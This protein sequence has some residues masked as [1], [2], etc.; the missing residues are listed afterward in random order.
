[1]S[2]NASVVNHRAEY[3]DVEIDAGTDVEGTW[4]CSG[5][6]NPSELSIDDG[7]ISAMVEDTDVDDVAP[8][9]TVVASAGCTRSSPAPGHWSLKVTANDSPPDL[10]VAGELDEGVETCGLSSQDE[11]ASLPITSEVVTAEELR[12]AMPKVQMERTSSLRGV[13]SVGQKLVLDSSDKENETRNGTNFR[14]ANEGRTCRL[15]SSKKVL[16]ECASQD[17]VGLSPQE[18]GGKSERSAIAEG[19]E[20]GDDMNSSLKLPLSNHRDAAATNFIPL[21]A[22]SGTITADWGSLDYV[23]IDDI[24]PEAPEHVLPVCENPAASAPDNDMF[25]GSD[26]GYGL[27]SLTRNEQNSASTTDTAGTRRT[28]SLEQDASTP[29]ARIRSSSKSPYKC[30][31]NGRK[32]SHDSWSSREEDRNERDVCGRQNKSQ[33]SPD[34]GSTHNHGAASSSHASAIVASLP[35]ARATIGAPN[36]STGLFAP[37]DDGCGFHFNGVWN[38]RTFTELQS[39]TAG[40]GQV[41]NSEVELEAE[42]GSSASEDEDLDLVAGYMGSTMSLDEAELLDVGM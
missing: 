24:A 8:G 34:S 21:P 18:T 6:A 28:A 23:G 36:W 20:G 12:S 15:I 37:E 39:K 40:D 38:A 42:K 9:G 30:T 4:E 13:C 29:P 5:Q 2:K 17:C 31:R 7:F 16:G 19:N 26:N 25:E 32:L 1:M 3:A 33:D 14:T 41:E 11:V 35:R 27:P 22:L 10:N